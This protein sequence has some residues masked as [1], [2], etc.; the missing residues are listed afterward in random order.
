MEIKEL[1]NENIVIA[2]DE[3]IPGYIARERCPKCG[4]ATIYHDGYDSLL[5]AFCNAWLENGCGDPACDRCA[6]RPERPLP[7]S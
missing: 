6:T 2:G 1:D 7:A 4:S 5:C 3:R